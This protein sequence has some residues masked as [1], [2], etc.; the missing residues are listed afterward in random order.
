MAHYL[1]TGTSSGIGAALC[2]RLTQAGHDVSGIARRKSHLGASAEKIGFFQGYQSDVVN[3][4]GLKK[5][6]IS[7]TGSDKCIC[8]TVIIAASK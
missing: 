5:T 7:P 8:M 1:I 4:K 3:K 2:T 6:K